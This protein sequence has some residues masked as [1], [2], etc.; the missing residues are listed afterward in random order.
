MTYGGINI[1]KLINLDAI[2][3]DIVLLS[4]LVRQNK[5]KKNNS[6]SGPMHWIAKKWSKTDY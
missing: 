3:I 2:Y 4:Y 5:M 6:Y 1:Y